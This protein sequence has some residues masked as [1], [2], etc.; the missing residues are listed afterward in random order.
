MNKKDI[1]NFLKDQYQKQD[2]T[3]VLLENQI[4]EKIISDAKE[5]KKISLEE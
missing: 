3:Q 5:R 4:D 1:L 2:E